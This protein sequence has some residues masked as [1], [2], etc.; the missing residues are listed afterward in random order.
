MSGDRYSLP[1]YGGFVRGFECESSL[2]LPRPQHKFTDYNNITRQPI[3]HNNTSLYKQSFNPSQLSLK[4]PL[5]PNVNSLAEASR[6]LPMDPRPPVWG[7]NYRDQYK[8]MER[9]PQSRLDKINASANIPQ[10]LAS[11]PSASN[12]LRAARNYD[13]ATA[14]QV[15]YGAKGETPL[16]RVSTHDEELKENPS[17]LNGMAT[18]REFFSGSAK[19]TL[20]YRVPGYSGHI[21]RS[22]HNRDAHIPVR[23]HSMP[24][25]TAG[26][27]L[28]P[29]VVPHHFEDFPPAQPRSED[30]NRYVK[31]NLLDSYRPNMSNYSGHVPKDVRNVTR[32]RSPSSMKPPKTSLQAGLILDSMKG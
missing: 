23:H 16:R 24:V 9:M 15:D 18:T 6:N 4:D 27:K 20:A 12:P 14:Y 31:D 1:G 26:S 21:P 30:Y 2:A 19:N 7:T 28:G 10:Y 32:P 13:W 17:V 8:R 11:I 25:V 3:Q 22:V 5:T 29:S